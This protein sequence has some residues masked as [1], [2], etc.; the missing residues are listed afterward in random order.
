ME[1]TET[2]TR[3]REERLRRGWTLTYLTQVTGISTADI[4]QIEWARRP[5]FPGWRRKLA[6]AF[7][8]PASELFPEE[9]AA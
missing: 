7:G 3:L 5:A 1:K 4:S 8:M 6:K 9:E 2:V